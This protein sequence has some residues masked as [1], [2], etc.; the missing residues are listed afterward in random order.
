MEE[1]FDTTLRRGFEFTANGKEFVVTGLW[2]I[3]AVQD[4][5]DIK[6]KSTGKVY[7]VTK[8]YLQEKGIL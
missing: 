5:Y 1:L 6:D 3:G 2:Y 7:N 8:K 4:S